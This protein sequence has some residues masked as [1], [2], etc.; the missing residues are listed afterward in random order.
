MLLCLMSHQQLYKVIWREGHSLVA[1]HKLVKQ[2]SEPVTPG[3]Q[4]GSRTKH[5]RTKH[6]MPFFDTPD[7]TSHKDLPPRTK[8][9]MLFLSPPHITSHAIFAAP[10]KTSHTISATPDKTS[11]LLGN[12]LVKTPLTNHPAFL[13][14]LDMIHV[15]IFL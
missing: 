15:T 10:D 6:P 8:H 13:V 4:G 5:P 3:L 11:H 12:F 9:P 1:S 2:G 14:S 7:K